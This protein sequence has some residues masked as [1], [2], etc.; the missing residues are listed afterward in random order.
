MRNSESCRLDNSMREST[1]R[2]AINKMYMGWV[3]NFL[4]VSLAVCGV[5]APAVVFGNIYLSKVWGSQSRTALILGCELMCEA[6]P[7]FIDEANNLRGT[8]NE[9]AE[10]VRSPFLMKFMPDKYELQKNL[11]D[12]SAYLSETL[13]SDELTQEKAATA[14]WQAGEE[15][16]RFRMRTAGLSVSEED[17]PKKAM[18]EWLKVKIKAAMGECEK[19]LQQ[20]KKDN[21]SKTALKLCED[22]R[23]AMVMIFL[24]RSDSN[25]SEYLQGF[26]TILE[27]A[28]ETKGKLAENAKNAGN[29]DESELLSI[30]VRSEQRRL[31]IIDAMLKPDNMSEVYSLLWDTISQTAAE[32]PKILELASKLNYG[33]NLG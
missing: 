6:G 5:L 23:F 25:V 26:R 9:Y 17:L 31:K 8:L 11:E 4:L 24:A 18:P 29:D 27:Q 1:T 30:F 14:I 10:C 12:W 16:V 15:I 28:I 32:R 33:E 3:R 7:D 21:R 20:L 19:T 13:D 2:R 22:D